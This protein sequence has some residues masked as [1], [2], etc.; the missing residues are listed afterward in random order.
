MKNEQLIEALPVSNNIDEPSPNLRYANEKYKRQVIVSENNTGNENE[1]VEDS[2]ENYI[3][4]VPVNSQVIDLS[5]NEQTKRQICNCPRNA[6]NYEKIYLYSNQN[7]IIFNEPTKQIIRPICQPKLASQIPIQMQPKSIVLNSAPNRL[8][9]C[10][11]CNQII[12]SPLCVNSIPNKCCQ[13]PPAIQCYQC[14][15]PYLPRPIPKVV[16]PIECSKTP[17]IAVRPPVCNS[18]VL[19]SKIVPPIAAAPQTEIC[20]RTLIPVSNPITPTTPIICN[21][22]LVSN[23]HS[24]ESC[25]F[26]IKTAIFNFNQ[27]EVTKV[28]AEL[29]KEIIE[30][31]KELNES[32]ENGC[33]CADDVIETNCNQCKTKQDLNNAMASLMNTIGQLN[34]NIGDNI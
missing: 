30:L 26:F 21:R 27:P 5:R 1:K 3:G 20:N 2:T 7:P 13:C 15:V 12:N 29:T 28:L 33:C 4:L 8:A 22:P 18:P 9:A 23:G 16:K 25:K 6:N 24:P 19:P 32:D 34:K 10:T 11:Q 31:R 14:S 17:T